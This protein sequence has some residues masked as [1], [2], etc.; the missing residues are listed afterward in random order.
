MVNRVPVFWLAF[1]VMVTIC[2]PT[3]CIYLEPDQNVGIP[4]GW[5]HLGLV[6]ATDTVILTFALKQQNTDRL[7]ELLISVSDPD[8]LQYGKYLSLNELSALVQPSELTSHTVHEWLLNYGVENCWTVQTLD[9]LQCS[10]EARTAEKLLPGSQFNRYVSGQQTIVRSP[11]PYRIY[12]GLAEHIDFVGGMHRFPSNRKVVSRAWVNKDR[13]ADLHLGVTPTVLR[14]QYNLT[15][16]DVG[17]FKNNSQACA[18]FLEQYFH[19]ADLAEFMTIFS[20]GFEHRSKVDQVIGHQA[21]G[22]AGLEASLDVEYIMS[23]GANISTWVFSNPGRYESQEPFLDWLLLLSNM[24][25][26]PWV[27]SVSYGDDEDSLSVAYMERVNVEFMK[28]GVRGATILFASGDAGAG[29]RKVRKDVNVFRPSFPASS[30]YVTTVGG[31]SLENPFQIT[32]EVTDYISGGGFS[33]VFPMPDYQTHAVKNYLSTMRKLP[34]VTYYNVSGRAYP[35]VAALSDN[36]WVVVNRIPIPWVSGTSASTP[37]FGGIIALINDRRFQKGLPSV[38]F[39]NP[40]LYKHQ[41]NGTS[42]ALFDVTEGCHLSCLDDQV[43]GQGFC[44]SVSWDPVT[45]WGTPNYPELLK[46]LLT[47]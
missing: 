37:V 23:A 27:H 45:G 35:D 21:G 46:T 5:T 10:M 7:K 20:R 28:A 3:R 6:E 22:R 24:S 13:R 39:L 15:A 19:P 40:R 30:P 17:S 43:Q 2:R 14:K 31:T 36:Y 42:K 4:V 33:N 34:P 44:A 11:V 8:S 32:Y 9:F 1:L 41:G 18:Q 25:F 38:G 26:I 12:E 16:S 47:K 29:C